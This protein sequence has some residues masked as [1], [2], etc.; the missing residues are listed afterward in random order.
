MSFF[1]HTPLLCCSHCRGPLMLFHSLLF[2]TGAVHMGGNNKYPV[3]GCAAVPGQEPRAGDGCV[4]VHSAGEPTAA[5]LLSLVHTTWQRLLW[6]LCSWLRLAGIRP[7]LK[8]LD[9]YSNN[10]NCVLQFC[11][12]N[13]SSKSRM[14]AVLILGSLCADTFSSAV[15]SLALSQFLK[16]GTKISVF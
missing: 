15:G 8:A 2:P 13:S 12:L 14:Q 16:T 1:P 10:W 9:T 7:R 3:P 5:A 11:S 4:P 6:A